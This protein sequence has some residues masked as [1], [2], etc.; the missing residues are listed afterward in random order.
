MSR[1]S[2]SVGGRST[3][4]IDMV[5]RTAGPASWPSAETDPPPTRMMRRHFRYECRVR[6]KAR[7]FRLD[8]PER[9]PRIGPLSG[10]P[11][12]WPTRSTARARLR[13]NSLNASTSTCTSHLAWPVARP[14][15][16]LLEDIEFGLLRQRIGPPGGDSRLGWRAGPSAGNPA[17]DPGVTF[18]RNRKIRLRPFGWISRPRVFSSPRPQVTADESAVKQQGGLGRMEP[19]TGDLGCPIKLG[20]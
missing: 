10:S 15:V 17:R 19:E 20:G 18:R 4:G 6:S 8:L 7:S 9:P 13:I 2:S 16:N 1:K 3:R 5:G 14:Q 12:S 11:V